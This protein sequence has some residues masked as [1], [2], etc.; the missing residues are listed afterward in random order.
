[1]PTQ[2]VIERLKELQIELERISTAVKHIDEAAKV[3]KSTSEILKKL[4]ELIIDLKALDEKHHQDLLKVH[5]EKIEA[6]EKQLQDLLIE[7]KEKSKQLNQLIDESKKLE[8]TIAD[9][10]SEI[11]K[12]N[13]PER[14]DKIDNQISSINIGVGNLQSA[15]QNTQ[16]KVDAL[17]FAINSFGQLIESKLL[18]MENQLSAKH[19][20]LIKNIRM[21]RIITI[22]IGTILL[23]GVGVVI[24]L[25]FRKFGI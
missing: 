9:Y 18:D 5:K 14:L 11:K 25:F 23:I 12:I 19:Q 6:L 8:K 7:L 20:K 16:S 1:M 17:Q 4:P 15:I 2:P 10:F 22:T 13:F 3:A 21:G 24:F